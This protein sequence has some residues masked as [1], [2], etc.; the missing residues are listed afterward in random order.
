MHR[1][2]LPAAVAGRCIGKAPYETVQSP[3]P[4]APA[5]F[6][7][8]NS[9]LTEISLL[10]CNKAD[11]GDAID[12]RIWALFQFLTEHVGIYL[13]INELGAMKLQ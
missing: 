9:S 10:Y 1:E 6:I 2:E 8:E 12:A 11:R 7:H 13:L 3:G 5:R 4:N